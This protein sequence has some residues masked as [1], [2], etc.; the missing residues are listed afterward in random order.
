MPRGPPQA[1]EPGLNRPGSFYQ[2]DFVA[3]VPPFI[4]RGHKA[5]TATARQQLADA[6]RKTKRGRYTVAPKIERTLDGI[7]FDSKGEMKRYALLKLREKIGEI[8]HLERQPTYKV[9]IDGKLLCTYRADFRYFETGNYV[10]EDFKSEG[11][12]RDTAWRLRKRAAEL[13]HKM[14]VHEIFA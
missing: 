13:Y 1:L 11:T 3:R 12:V 2:S 7:V 6:T 5:L 14:I 9:F 8:S 4:V 10:V